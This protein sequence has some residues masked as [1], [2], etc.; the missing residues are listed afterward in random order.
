MPDPFA[1]EKTLSTPTGEFRYFDLHALEAAGLGS[2]QRLP[3]SIRVL[4]EA[5]LRNFDDYVVDE[6]HI[7]ALMA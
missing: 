1:A 5:A 2:L 3:Y 6:T 7:R 4:L